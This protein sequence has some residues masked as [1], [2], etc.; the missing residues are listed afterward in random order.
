MAPTTKKNNKR[1]S[2]QSS[3]PAAKKAKIPVESSSEDDELDNV[4]SSD[5]DLDEI[6]SDDSDSQSMSEQEEDDDNDEE[7]T[8]PKKEG[9]GSDNHTEQ[10]KLLKERKLQR[11]SGSEIQQIKNVWERLRVKS[12]P[13]PKEIREKLCNEIWELSKEHF[14][15]LILKHD[16]SRIVQTL[17]KYSSKERREEIINALKGKYYVLATSSYGKYLLVKLLHYGTKNS[18][19][20]IIN[21]LHGNLRK[22]MRHREGAYVVEDLYVLYATSEQRNQMIREF[23]GSEY[24]VFRDDHKDLKIEDICNSSVEKRSIISKNLLGTISASVE[25]GSTGFQI[26]HA[27]MREFVKIADDSQISEMIELLHEQFAELVHTPEG[28]D[29]ACTLI[30]KASAKERK[31]ILRSLKEHADKLIPNEH[32]HMVFINILMVVDDT[33]LVFKTFGAAIK[34]AFADFATDK[35][36]RR[37]LIYLL[38]GLNGKYFSPI[39]KKE[40]ERYFEMASKTSKKDPVVRK[41]ELV[42]KFSNILLN[43]VGTKYATILPDNIGSQFFSELLTCDEFYA[44]LDEKNVAKY[45]EILNSVT[46]YFKG[47]VTEKKH[48]VHDAFST[49]FLKSLISGGKWDSKERKVIPFE[50]I[51]GL[52]VPFATKFYDEIIDSTNLLV[53]INEKD[54]S[55]TIVALYETLNNTEEGKQFIKDLK[56]VKKNINV[57]SSNKGAQLLLKLMK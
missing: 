41:Q 21:E 12:P 50:H 2:P 48:P 19:Q 46:V 28:A 42:A 56:S 23:W 37:P 29:V 10:R 20:V 9:E 5:D 32:G 57:D 30:S 26:L 33:V 8:E 31:L 1:S 43:G 25:K 40:L 49:R 17:I 15:D 55:F 24:A 34:D 11:R 52:G 38:M 14:S 27:A 16:A 18:R 13:L 6:V 45:E 4:S 39:I 54:C 53:W 51:K 22:L 3:K 44:Q 36:G 35:Y 7:S 47:D